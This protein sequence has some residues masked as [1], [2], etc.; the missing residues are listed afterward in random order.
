MHASRLFDVASVMGVVGSSRS[1]SNVLLA[2]GLPRRE[3]GFRITRA[4]PD[5]NLLHLHL[6]L[7]VGGLQG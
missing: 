3:P 1:S 2:M 6:Q 4:H 5:S 7:G